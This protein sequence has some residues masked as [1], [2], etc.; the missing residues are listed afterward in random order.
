MG[1]IRGRR[2]EARIPITASGADP[3]L[4]SSLHGETRAKL[5]CSVGDEERACEAGALI[6]DE[7]LV[8]SRVP[9]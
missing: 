2:M 8:M 6:A 7:T 5:A 9:R 4:V 1:P 3:P